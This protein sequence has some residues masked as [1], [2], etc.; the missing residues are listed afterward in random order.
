MQLL[1]NYVLHLR[2]DWA[3]INTTMVLVALF[4]LTLP[5]MLQLRRL[6]RQCTRDL[7]RI[8][9]QLDLMRLDA[10]EQLAEAAARDSVPTLPQGAARAQQGHATPPAP[11]GAE[12]VDYRAAA[13]LAERGTSI[14]E[15]AARCGLASG[16]ARVLVA[17][18][19]ARARQAV[20][21]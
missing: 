15:I 2:F 10:Q 18:K 13:R 16:E 9:E 11:G 21:S 7:Q 12:T 3:A 19:Q 17:L 14:S 8:F 6:R 5:L 4:G 20:S 1:T